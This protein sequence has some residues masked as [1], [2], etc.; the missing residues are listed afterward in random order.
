MTKNPPELDWSGAVSALRDSQSVLLVAHVTPDA[1]ALGSALALGMALRTMGKNVQVSV[2]ESG[3]EVPASLNF[4]PGIELVVSPEQVASPDVIVVCDTSSLE[5]LGVLASIVTSAE[6]SIAIDHHPTFNGFGTIHIIDP[7]APATASLALKLIDL[8][9]V[10]VSKDIAAAIYAGLVTDTGS[11]KFQ[12]T[13]SE[14][15][16]TA[17]RLFDLGIDHSSLA[18]QLFDDEPF[19][20]LQVLGSAIDRAVLLTAAAGGHGLVYT[21][22]SRS[23]RGELSE[24][25]MERVIDT[26]RRT[27]EAEVAAVF[28]QTDEGIWKGSLRSKTTINVGSVARALGGGGHTYAAGYTGTTDIDS[29]ISAL[30]DELENVS[31]V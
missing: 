27:H 5:R 17:A 13:T 7:D 14:T 20:A 23:D 19:T 26:L 18:R 16:R 22:V 21:T 1:D 24:L 25:A 4:L 8:L 29:M 15:L 2:G 9:D 31:G 28:K 6:V 30:C 11:F 3:F 12:G 10:E